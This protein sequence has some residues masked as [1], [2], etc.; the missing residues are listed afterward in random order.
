M[1]KRIFGSIIAIFALCFS[2]AA[3]RITYSEPERVD[4]RD[5]NFDII[6]KMNGNFLVYK[7]VRWK[8]AIS[9]YNTEM[10]LNERVVLDYIPDKTFNIDFV[11]YPDFAWMV[12]Q[13]QKKSIVYCMGVKIGSDGKA[14]G[15]PVQ[16][17]TTKIDIAATNKIYT[18]IN[19]ENKQ[20]IMIFKIYKK[21][22]KYNFVSL[23]FNDK[24]Q[25]QRK[26]RQQVPFDDRKDGYSEF[27]IDNEGVFLFTKSSRSG[28]RDNIG[29]LKLVT[30]QPTS[31][32]FTYRTIKLDENYLDEIKLKVD[33][34]NKNYL[35]N[36]FYYKQRRGNIEGL[37]SC[38]WDKTVDSS[39]VSVFSV[40][41]D[42][43]RY[44]AKSQGQLKYALNDFF[45]RQV[46]VKKDGSFLLT[47]EDYSTQSRGGFGNNNGW[48]R[49]DYLNSPY[50]SPY[51][52]YL[53]SPGYNSFYRPFN[54]FN[55]AQSIRYFY[56]KV[57]LL[58]VDK[59]GMIDW[60]N[61]IHKDQ[62]EDD[63][64]NFLSYGTMNAAGEIHFFFNEQERRN[65][66][67]SWQSVS[68]TGGLRRNPTLKSEGK[69]YQFMPRFMKQVGARQ[70]IMP[71]TY[72]GNVCFAKIE[73]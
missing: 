12:Y 68:G 58:S 72:R 63:N 62:F 24:M 39:V 2:A 55:N 33:N 50:L 48:N 59:S 54:S 22:D 37:Y 51:D 30:R 35:I 67:V 16:L 40:F 10:E 66:I 57:L 46:I 31:D 53:Y 41:D 6:G 5:I 69:G 21:H 17:D 47:A 20:H 26:C 34:V 13:Y 8:H 36:S 42:S 70:I 1:S 4:D 3:Q 28:N 15:E 27:F 49:W 29:T 23:L 19:S 45:I 32:T 18:T 56:D 38:V 65:Q 71:C 73:F 43:I 60:S 61:V 11:T 25:L 14:I 7:N 44:N 9:V 64:D 52:Y